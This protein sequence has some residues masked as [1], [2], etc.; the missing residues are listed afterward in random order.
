MV[1]SATVPTNNTSA[2]TIL[3]N[4]Q[5]I[6][7]GVANVNEI[8]NEFFFHF[9]TSG[10]TSEYAK[11]IVYPKKRKGKGNRAVMSIKYKVSA[12]WLSYSSDAFA[13]WLNEQS[14]YEDI[15]EVTLSMCWNLID[16]NIKKCFSFFVKIKD[17]ANIN[18]YINGIYRSCISS[19]KPEIYIESDLDNNKLIVDREFEVEIFKVEVYKDKK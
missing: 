13:E 8:Y 9:D 18:A 14:Y 15:R 12:C 2:K 19:A 7:Y 10:I 11:F 4:K 3:I 1:L 16:S 6:I 5:K 17:L